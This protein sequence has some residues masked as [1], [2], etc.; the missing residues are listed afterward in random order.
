MTNWTMHSKQ[1]EVW[2]DSSRFK[3]VTAGRRG[4]KSELGAMWVGAKARDEALKGNE[5]VIW[6]VLPTSTELGTIWRKFKHI[7][8]ED[9]ITD[10]SGTEKRPDFLKIGDIII[11]FR[12]A[13][14]PDR[15]V[16]EG[17]RAVWLDEA[18]IMLR[19]NDIW[20]EYVRPT[21]IDYKAPALISGT[22]KGKNKFFELFSRGQDDQQEKDASF[23]WTS[24]A[25]PYVPAD[26]IEDIANDMPERI[27]NQEI[28]AEFLD[29]T[30]SVFRG[31]DDAVVGYSDAETVAV[32]VD[33]A[34]AE[35]YTVLIGLDENGQVTFFDRFNELS[36]PLQK[37]RIV[38]KASETGAFFL[39]D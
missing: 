14:R 6:V 39:I 25:N 9:W 29:D 19:D 8:P 7:I 22:P 15:L 31:V 11:Q 5:G 33:L 35:D 37:K 38:S 2:D 30:A 28:L 10:K 20:A 32:G 1:M 27:Y 21:L 12:S 18:G 3:A 24:F 26:E 16:A 4:G 36:W 17:L 34:K 13:D 23:H